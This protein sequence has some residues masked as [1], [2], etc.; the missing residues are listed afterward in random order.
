VKSHRRLLVCKVGFSFFGNQKVMQKPVLTRWNIRVS[1]FR[2]YQLVS[3][4]HG[5]QLGGGGRSRLLDPLIMDVRYNLD[6][7][8]F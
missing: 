5:P 8:G 4:S 1:M 2:M 6:N 7:D 3:D